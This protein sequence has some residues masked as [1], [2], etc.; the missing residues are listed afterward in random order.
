[1]LLVAQVH[2]AR[3]AHVPY[4]LGVRHARLTLGTVCFLALSFPVAC[5]STSTSGAASGTFVDFETAEYSLAPSEE[6][7][8]CY[9]KT[10]EEDLAVD[11]FDYVAAPGVHHAIFSRTLA[12][13]PDGFSECK[14]LLRTTW[15]PMFASAT[16]GVSLET[17]KGAGVILPKGTQLLV[18]LHLLN[19]TSAPLTS[20]YRLK[21]RKSTVV[22]PEPVGIYAFGSTGLVVPPRMRSEQSDACTVPAA[23]DAFAAIAH[24]HYTG[25]SFRFEAGPSDGELKEIFRLDKFEFE[26]QV[27][28]PIELK[29]PAGWRTRV[30]C[31]F[32]NPYD[33]ELKFGESSLDEMCFFV[34]FARN[35][36]GLT[37]CSAS[38]G[39]LGGASPDCGKKPPNDLGIGKACTKGGKECG[40]GMSCTLDQA[41]T[42]EGSP[43]FCFKVG[44]ATSAECGG[45]GAVCC[46]PKQ[47]GGVLKVCM[48]ESCKPS[49]CELAP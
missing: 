16:S 21:M 36:E 45:G 14:V 8:L 25:K 11:R 44:C 24:M 23:L 30:T 38:S 18:Q 29:L 20:R 13:E 27:V 17:P 49:D 32:D 40:A 35:R 3:A 41:S 10:L 48:P 12:P 15:V 1:M 43:G 2:L 19:A 31:T 33:H 46:A 39:G 28:A 4:W 47:A 7:F 37:G 26:K 34:T 42:P 22:D 5:S 9:A 6:K